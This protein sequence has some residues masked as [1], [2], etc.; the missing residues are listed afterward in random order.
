MGRNGIIKNG[1]IEE[2]KSQVGLT[3]TSASLQVGI[4]SIFIIMLPWTTK[5][6]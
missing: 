1:G 6:Y 4:G 5:N 3:W 2:S